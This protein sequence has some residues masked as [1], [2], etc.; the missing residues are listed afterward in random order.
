MK[1]LLPA[2]I[3]LEIR[4]I[5]SLEALQKFLQ[6]LLA[7][8]LSHRDF[9]AVQTLLSVCLRIH[10]D[11]IIENDELEGLLSELYAV[12]KEESD[13]ITAQISSALGMLDFIRN[14]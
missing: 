1:K 8:L 11:I 7:R 10:G 13:R 9:E 4:T 14:P 6:A 5:S 3:D 2:A 12:Q